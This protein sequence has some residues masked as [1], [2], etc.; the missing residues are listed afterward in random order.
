[1]ITSFWAHILPM[2]SAHIVGKNPRRVRAIAAVFLRNRQNVS[3]EISLYYINENYDNILV[4]CKDF[5]RPNKWNF[6]F[7]LKIRLHIFYKFLNKRIDS[8]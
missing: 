5:S 2:G 4:F 3:I 7:F 1:V 8:F 6:V